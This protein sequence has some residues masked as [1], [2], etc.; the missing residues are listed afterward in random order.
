MARDQR[1]DAQAATARAPPAAMVMNISSSAGLSGAQFLETEAALDDRGGELAAAQPHRAG[2]SA[3]AC[4]SFASGVAAATI[5]RAAQSAAVNG[6][7]RAT[8]RTE[9]SGSDA[10]ETAFVAQFAFVQDRDAIAAGEHVRQHVCRQHDRVIGAEAA[11]ELAQAKRLH[12]IEAGRRLVEHDQIGFVQDRL[13]KTD[14]LAKALRER[15]DQ[16]APHVAEPAAFDRACDRRVGA[17]APA[18]AAARRTRGTR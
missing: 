7:R 12:G 9:P 6:F 15:A 17:R 14:A 3:S 18:R 1:G 11:H 16:P 10:R 13:R 2:E 5:G 4:A 8:S